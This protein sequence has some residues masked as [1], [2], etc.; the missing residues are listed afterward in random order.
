MTKSLLVRRLA[1][2]FCAFVGSSV[3]A[4][5]T[6]PASALADDRALPQVDADADPLSDRGLDAMVDAEATARRERALRGPTPPDLPIHEGEVLTA[7]SGVRESGHAVEITLG[8]GLAVATHALRFTSTARVPTEIRYRLAVPYGAWL[9][10]LEVCD[11]RG[12]RAGEVRGDAGS[13]AYDDSVRSR[14]TPR[15]G[16][17]LP[18]GHAVRVHDARGEAIVLRAAPVRAGVELT[19]RVRWVAPAVLHGGVTRIVLPARGQDPR[20]SAASVTVRAPGMLAATADGLTTDDAAVTVE[21]WFPAELAATLPSGAPVSTSAWRVRCGAQTCARVRASAGAR[22]GAPVDLVLLIDASPST[23]GPARG[24]VQPAIAAL[25]AAAPPGSRVRAVAFGS[26]AETVIGEPVDT[27]RAP[28]VPLAQA[29][30][31]ELGSATRLETAWQLVEPW[32]AAARRENASTPPPLLVLVGD[33][34]LSASPETDGA[35]AEIVASRIPFSV[36]D[37]GE[38]AP[39]AHLLET[40]QRTGGV[41]VRVTAREAE[42]AKLDELIAEVF[43]PIVAQEVV[44]HVGRTTRRLGALRAGEERTW[45]AAYAGGEVQLGVGR[46]SVTARTPAEPLATALSLGLRDGDDAQ[47]LAA[48]ALPAT[49]A[50]MT[51]SGEPA[52]PGAGAACVPYGPATYPSGVSSDAA[53]VALAESRTCHAPA[54]AEREPG[55]LPTNVQGRPLDGRGVPAETLLAM[56]HARVVPAARACFRADRAGRSDYSVRAGIAFELADREILS[57][58]ITGELAPP[59]RSCLLEALDRLEVPRFEGTVVVRY[60]VYTEAAPPP[61]TIE[62]GGTAAQRVD[63]TFGDGVRVEDVRQLPRR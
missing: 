30:Q 5:G 32:F 51:T 14:P 38:R 54:V 43:A 1:V 25:L 24:R 28:L 46:V 53:P 62:L 41:V 13:A 3:L 57:T 16:P 23:L 37:V 56:L 8:D 29:A 4:R 17:W 34:G 27:S 11:V 40:A 9:A 58:S 48:V 6:L 63:R 20:A 15:G 47:A 49:R 18:V 7:P 50:A 35:L 60:P 19:L 21:P 52:P 55:E 10:A 33:G 2:I 61:P 59:L 45:T 44:V 36:I 39:V 12:C 31:T 42:A 22:P 26:R